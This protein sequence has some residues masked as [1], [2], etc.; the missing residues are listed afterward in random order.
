MLLIKH[1]LRKNGKYI[2]TYTLKVLCIIIKQIDSFTAEFFNIYV[3]YFCIQNE[4]ATLKET[5]VTE[6]KE[7]E[8]KSR[9]RLD[10]EWKLQEDGLRER[11]RKER[12]AEL[13]RVVQKLEA[14][15]ITGRKTMESEFSE[16]MRLVFLLSQL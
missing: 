4:I 1:I 3:Y 11:F 8:R 14:E 12:D 15:V 9:Q 10:E 5:E 16:R 2:I 13:D 6:R 7:W